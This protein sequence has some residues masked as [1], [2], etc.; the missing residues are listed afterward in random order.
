[1]DFAMVAPTQWDREL[2]ADLTAK[3]RRLG[4]AQMMGIGR[5]PAADQA[6]LFRNRFDMLPIANAARHRQCQDALVNNRSALPFF[7]SCRTKDR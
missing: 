7:A 1:M 2:I 5:T 6:S 4:K 3:G